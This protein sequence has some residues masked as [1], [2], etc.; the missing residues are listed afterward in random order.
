MAKADLT[1]IQ[2]AGSSWLKSVAGYFCV[3]KIHAGADLAISTKP[4]QEHE[5]RINPVLQVLVDLAGS[6][7]PI[8]SKCH[9]VSLPGGDR[10]GMDE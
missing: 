2:S 5:I 6:G 3:G 9:C 4:P 7:L 10:V 8:A 1:S